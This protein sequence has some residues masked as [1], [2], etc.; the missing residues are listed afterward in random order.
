M[1][2]AGELIQRRKGYGRPQTLSKVAVELAINNNKDGASIVTLALAL[3][4][5]FPFSG[6]QHIIFF[7]IFLF[8][9]TNHTCIL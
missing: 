7:Q 1:V 8:L 2:D 5:I 9:M 3:I 4:C 6:R